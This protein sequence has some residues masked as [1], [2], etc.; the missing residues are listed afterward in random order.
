MKTLALNDICFAI[1]KRGLAQAM[2]VW[3][4][5][6]WVP[7]GSEA[8]FRYVASTAR[9][10]SRWGLTKGDRL[11]I[12]PENRPES[13]VAKFSPLLLGAVVV[14]G[15]KVT[16]CT[17]KHLQRVLSIKHQTVVEHVVMIDQPEST[18]YTCAGCC[19]QDGRSAM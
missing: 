16:V 15:A 1:V 7:I 2:P 10:F 6:K 19:M 17:E 5:N 4:T 9:V 14:P 12:L 8:F 18:A 11:A 3:G 13:A